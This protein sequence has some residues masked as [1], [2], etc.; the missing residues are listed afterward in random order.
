MLAYYDERAG[1]YEEAYTGGTG[2]SS[3]DDG[4]IFVREAAVLSRVASG[5]A[6]GR[7]I[8][9]ACGTGYWLPFY[10]QACTSITLL[11]QSPKM[12]AECRRKTEALGIT[13]KCRF[14]LDDVFVHDFRGE[15][16][17]SLLAGFLLSHLTL[18]EEAAFFETLRSILQPAGRFLIFDSAWTGTR[19]QAN[20]RE[21]RQTRRLNDG[22]AFQV[23]KR[24][25]DETDVGRWQEEHDA[26]MAVDFLG[27]AFIAVS[28]TFKE[29]Q[30]CSTSVGESSAP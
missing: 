6:G 29:V 16:F 7:L 26:T 3:L 14:E 10:H 1:E 19:A 23:Y 25:L 21:E 5:V 30:R 15:R 18:A 2:T 9:V 17:D 12:L 13:G 8:D 4:S 11:D 28:G 27:D 22:T 24:Y 20:A